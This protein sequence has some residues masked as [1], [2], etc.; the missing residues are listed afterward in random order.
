M[1]AEQIAARVWP[2]RE[3]EHRAARRRHH[4]P[5]LRR[6]RRREGVRAPDRGRGHRAPRYRPRRG[7]RGGPHRSRAR[8]RTRGRRLRRRVADH[9]LRRRRHRPGRRDPPARRP[10]RGRGTAPA[11]PRR[12]ALPRDVR[13]LSSRRGLPR[14]SGGARR[15]NPGP[16]RG[17][18]GPRR[19]DRTHARHPAGAAVSQRPAERQLH[20]LAGRDPDRRLGV[21]RHG[22]PVLR[23]RE[24]LRQPRA[25]GG[26]E[27][28]RCSTPTSA[29]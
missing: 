2:D 3:L 25:V 19:R 11:H 1:R 5:Q 18:Q 28:R 9:V 24:L 27:R 8:G 26:R 23:P 16:V 17:G 14:D 29:R 6:P 20:P 7:A 10:A 15:P 12:P 4:E 22:R 21:R 13:R